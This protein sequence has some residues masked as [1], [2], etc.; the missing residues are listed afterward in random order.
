MNLEGSMYEIPGTIGQIE[1]NSAL[2]MQ[3]KN[4]LE[5]ALD[6]E[7]QLANFIEK[8]CN[9]HLTYLDKKFERLQKAHIKI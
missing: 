1:S 5:N 4:L 2:V 8:L 9:E 3:L 7:N 6:R